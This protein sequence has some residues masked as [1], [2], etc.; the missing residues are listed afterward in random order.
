VTATP[1]GF[2]FVHWT[3]A[4]KVVRHVGDVHVTLTPIPLVADFAALEIHHYVRASP[5]ADGTVSEVAHSGRHST[6]VTATPKSGFNFV[7]WTD[8]GKVV[9]TSE[10]YTFTL[11]A[12]PA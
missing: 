4:G 10:M 5:A 6:T 3:N 2:D 1:D 9:S 12:T 8:A 11:N 7:H